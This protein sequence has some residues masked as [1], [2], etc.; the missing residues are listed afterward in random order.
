MYNDSRKRAAMRYMATLKEIRFRV[1]LEY[2]DKICVLASAEGFPS[3]R[4][5]ILYCIDQQL[6]KYYND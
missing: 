3:I 2:F 5:F 4:Q 6:K 1:K